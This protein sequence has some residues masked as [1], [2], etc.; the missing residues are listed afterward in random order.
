MFLYQG[1][2]SKLVPK[3]TNC[4][5]KK[6]R[7]NPDHFVTKL[8]R[9]FGQAIREILSRSADAHIV[10]N[11]SFTSRFFPVIWEISLISKVCMRNRPIAHDVTAPMTMHLED[12]LAI[13]A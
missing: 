13:Y 10:F 1:E 5:S 4:I 3:E 7:M 12:K 9:R 2:S 11:I 8:Y 6:K